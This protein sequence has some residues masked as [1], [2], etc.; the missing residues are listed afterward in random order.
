MDFKRMI[1]LYPPQDLPEE[2]GEVRS[3]YTS[4]GKLKHMKHQAELD[5]HGFTVDSALPEVSRFLH[6]SSSRGLKKVLIIFGKGYHSETG[7]VL[8]GAVRRY[9]ESS[10]LAGQLT[11]P[12]PKY[13]GSGAL[14]VLIR[15]G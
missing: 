13:G 5:L 11:T 8:P 2:D 7:P 12:P 3:K 1:D 10:P 4:P 9:L 14:W 6:S 15:K